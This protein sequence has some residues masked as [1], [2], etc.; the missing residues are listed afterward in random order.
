[1][2][3]SQKWMEEAIGLARRGEKTVAP[4]PM[5]GALVVHDG[6]VIG[7]GWHERA[8]EGHAEIQAIADARQQADSLAGAT[9]VVTLEPCS[10]H[11]RTPPCTEAILREGFAKVI[12]G[13]VDPNP[14]HEGRGIQILLE[15]GLEVE[16]GVL[17]AECEALLEF[18]EE[19]PGTPGT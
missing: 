14:K 18:W 6:Q 12:V 2:N 8:G 11:G 4:N 7:R 19:N 1:M 5:V 9:L 16:T 17:E 3:S 15:A 10:T 13:A